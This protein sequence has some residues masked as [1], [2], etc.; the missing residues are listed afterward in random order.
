MSLVALRNTQVKI[1]AHFLNI[2]GIRIIKK[3]K[4]KKINK[5]SKQKPSVWNYSVVK[6][7]EMSYNMLL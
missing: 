1:F 6:F 3:I 2:N 7:F 4:N 5:N